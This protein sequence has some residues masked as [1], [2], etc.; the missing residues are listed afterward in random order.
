MHY[1]SLPIVM[2]SKP[3]ALCA[4]QLR[5]YAPLSEA[6]PALEVVV[7]FCRESAV[8]ID[9]QQ[10]ID[11]ALRDMV[12]AGVRTLLV[13][14]DGRVEGL[15]TAY[16][17]QGEKPIRFVQSSDCIHHPKC[18]HEDVQVDDIMT[19]LAKLPMLSMSDIATACVGNVRETFRQTGH[20]HLLVTE[21]HADGQLAIRGLVSRVQVER[22]LGVSPN[23]ADMHLIEHEMARLFAS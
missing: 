1:P 19:P 21:T 18:R 4:R 14:A 2:T 10:R 3:A 16:D 7:D 12:T 6:A 17:I 13:I 20:T 11:V 5:D 15:I 8:T 9:P 23:A 22:Q